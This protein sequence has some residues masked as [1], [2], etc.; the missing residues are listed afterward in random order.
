MPAQEVGGDFFQI[1]PDGVGGMLI[2][3]GDVAGKGL[4]AAMLG[5]VIVGAARAT[6]EFTVDPSLVLRN[7]NDRLVGR[8]GGAFST[9]LVAH[10]SANGQARIANAGQLPPYLDGREIELPGA[11]PLGVQPGT[12]YQEIACELPQG[13]RLTLYSDGVVEAQSRTGELL[14][15]ERARDLA[16][17]SAREIAQVAQEFGQ[18]DDITV[19]TIDR[20]LAH[21]AVAASA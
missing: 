21:S 14:G 8:A 1:I 17:K 7:L 12:E 15:F 16:A 6:A 3:I 10:V 18:E 19:L 13:S 20:V 5:S 4:P 9:A 11:L 2:L